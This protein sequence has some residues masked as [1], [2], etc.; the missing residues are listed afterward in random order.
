[1]ITFTN[2]AASEMKERIG[3]EKL[4]YI[5][6]FHSLCARILRIHG[7]KIGVPGHY[8]IYDEADQL[9]LIKK[10]VGQAAKVQSTPSYILYRISTAKNEL[11]T[12]QKF[13][14]IF[15]DRFS[16]E[17]AKIYK[18]YQKELR[19]NSA[20]D[21]DDLLSLTIELFSTFPDVLRRYQERYK[22]ILVDEFQDTNHAQYVFTKMLGARYNNATVVGDFSQSI[23]SWRGADIGNLE[24][25]R[26]DFPKTKLFYLEKNYRSSQNILN[27]AYRVIAQNKTHPILQLTSENMLG[28]QVVFFEAETEE[29]EGL[30]V[31][32]EIE[33][34]KNH[35]PYKMFAVLY[36][37]NAQSRIIEEAFLHYGIPYVLVGG[38]RFYER[39]EIKDVLAYMRLIVNP[40]DQV[41]KDRVIKLGKKRWERFQPFYEKMKN[42]Y[43]TLSTEEIMEKIFESTQYLNLYN[44]SDPEDFA[45]LENIKEL[46]SVAVS[47]SNLIEFLEQ[48][49]LVE[50][51]YFEGEKKARG[52]HGV[53]LM[54]LHQAKGLEFD[55]VFIVG[56]EEG[57]LP[58]SRSL[59]DYLQLEEERR[60]FYVGITRARKYLY[61]TYT[62]RRFMF[63]RRNYAMKS[64]FLLESGEG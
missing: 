1:M 13:D 27:F 44:P 53:K 56:V 30:F 15:A 58:H 43:A 34:L 28:E 12:A 16:K 3:Q 22:Y 25:F 52:H 4:G 7:E 36:R 9:A 59:D 37:T 55:C 21:F 24:K 60:L 8:T 49:A 10:L 51:E 38:T 64:R 50:S 45:R 18:L 42:S 20:L 62:K 46:K 48:I 39:K 5:G 54:T 41:A 23:Y 61:I 26:K 40:A 32:E 31:V 29:Q 11:I 57:L 47:F 19:K 35:F 6:T 2:K 63:G 17:I 33:R 14:E